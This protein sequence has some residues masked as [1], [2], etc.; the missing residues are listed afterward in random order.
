[1]KKILDSLGLEATNPGTWLGSESSEDSSA[2]LIESTNPA[3][4]ELIASVRSTTPVEYE[5]LVTAARES[6][7]EWRKIPAPVRGA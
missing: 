4:G 7:E 5:R 1:M 6:F 2:S 3:N